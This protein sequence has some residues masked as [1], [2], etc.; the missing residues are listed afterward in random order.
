MRERGWCLLAV[1]LLIAA[2]GGSGSNP[3][4]TGGTG[5]GGA[6]G[7]ACANLA[8]LQHVED[9]MF[10][11]MGAACVAETA[12]IPPNTKCFGN[13]VKIMQTVEMTTGSTG[14]TVTTTDHLKKDDAVCYTTTIV[15][16][17]ATDG[18]RIQADTS[19][20]DAAGTTVVTGSQDS[21]DVITVTCPGHPPTT[22][23]ASCMLDSFYAT[24]AYVTEANLPRCADQTCSF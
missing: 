5:G 23:V 19:T 14:Y 1:P 17:Y 7:D 3:T 16:R 18:T 2:C 4:G 12:P 21:N 24:S 15:Q 9:L 10:A 13:G 6:S 20:Q 11:C 8:C 22:F